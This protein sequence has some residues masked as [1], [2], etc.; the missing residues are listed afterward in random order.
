M[1]NSKKA[2][3]A[4]VL[5]ATVF[6]TAPA[7]VPGADFG[8]V[9]SAEESSALS[10]TTFTG[11]VTKVTEKAIMLESVSDSALGS[12]VAVSG[13]NVGSF[14]NGDVVEVTYSG[15]VG[16]MNGTKTVTADSI[17]KV[18]NDTPAVDETPVV[19]EKPT[20]DIPAITETKPADTSKPADKTPNTGDKGVEFMATVGVLAGVVITIN[21][22]RNK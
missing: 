11:T 21:K 15:A 6:S 20:E 14:A 12:K 10:A 1:F 19:E 13:S 16:E 17:K 18:S 5:A 4:F 8:I 7:I 3:G 2:I 9:A 22:R